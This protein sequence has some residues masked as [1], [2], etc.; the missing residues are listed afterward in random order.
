MVFLAEETL[1]TE[2]T[3]ELGVRNLLNS[4]NLIKIKAAPV[5]NEMGLV[6]PDV[7]YIGDDETDIPDGK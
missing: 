6:Q 1:T 5:L 2:E 4:V 7:A 3:L